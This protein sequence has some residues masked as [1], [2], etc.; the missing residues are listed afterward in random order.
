[1]KEVFLA[2]TVDKVQSSLI[3]ETDFRAMVNPSRKKNITECAK[4]L[5]QKLATK[6]PACQSIGWGIV[7]YEKGLP[8]RDC[9]ARANREVSAEVFGCPKCNHREQ[10]LVDAFASPANCDFCNP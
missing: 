4:L 8:C 10:R 1:M 5:A 6:C 9:G 3:V 2:A 7:D